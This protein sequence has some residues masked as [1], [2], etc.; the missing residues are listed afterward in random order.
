MLSATSSESRFPAKNRYKT[1]LEMVPYAASNSVPFA[2]PM[3]PSVLS[4]VDV[5]SCWVTIADPYWASSTPSILMAFV[6]VGIANKA[7]TKIAERIDFITF[8]LLIRPPISQAPSSIEAL[9]HLPLSHG[10]ISCQLLNA[11]KSV[12]ALFLD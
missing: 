6:V 8:G 10:P 2:W 1:P 7:A 9:Y 3:S 11:S 4:E 5:L 12:A